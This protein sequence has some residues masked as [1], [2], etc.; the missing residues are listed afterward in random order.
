MNKLPKGHESLLSPTFKYVPAVKT[1]VSETFARVRRRLALPG[2]PASTVSVLK[3][4]K[5]VT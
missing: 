5:A 4:R 3:P 1:D 2:Q